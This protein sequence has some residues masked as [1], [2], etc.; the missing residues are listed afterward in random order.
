[1][2][3]NTA[4]LLA[5]N[6]DSHIV[7]DAGAGTGKTSTIVDRVIEHYLCEDQRATRILPKP[8]RP[9]RLQSGLLVSGSAERIDLRKWGGLLPGEVVL[10]TFTNRA[11]DEMR[12]RLRKRISR[13]KPGSA[14]DDGTYRKDP[15]IRHQGFNE[16]LLTLLDDAPIGTIDSF[17]NQ[18]VAPYRGILGDA[19]SREN[20]SD[21]GRILLTESALNTL[22]RLPNSPNL[23]GEA[24]DAGI[25]AE[26]AESVLAARDRI[27]RHYSGRRRATSVLRSLVNRSVFIEE[28]I[29]NLLDEKDAISEELLL[30][31]ILESI[32][33]KSLNG[34]TEE[35]HRLIDEYC[36]SVKSHIADLGGAWDANTRIACLDR[37][38]DDGPGDQVW[39]KLIWLGHILQCTANRSTW[40]N[41][42]ITFFPR[43]SLPN[44]DWPKGIENFGSLKSIFDVIVKSFNELWSTT[45]GQTYLHFTRT[46]ILL[47]ETPP[48]CSNEN[49]QSPLATLPEELPEVAPTVGKGTAH[50]FSLS[51]EARNLDDLRLILRGF[52]GILAKLKARDEVHDFDD[53]Q[54]LAGDLLLANCPEACREFYHP[55]IQSALDKPSDE[56]WRD[57]NIFTAFAA[58][59]ALEA[60]PSRAGEAAA[61]LGQIRTD[62]THRY[63]L[64]K[65]IR[66]RYRAFII[67]EAQDNSPLQ[68]RLLARLWGEREWVDGDPEIPNTP[69]QPTVCYVGDVKQSIYAFRQAEVTGFRTYA[70]TLRE[71]NKQ[72]FASLSELTRNPS[73]RSETHSRD[74]RNDHPLTIVQ[75]T[76]IWKDGG[77][78]LVGWIP[79]DATDQGLSSPSQEE[80][81]KRV[82]G[83]VSLN[84]NYRTDGGLLRVMN[85]WWTDIFSPRHRTV[86]SGDF[87]ADSQELFACPDLTKS[88]GSIEWLCPLNKEIT[89]DPPTDLYE[90]LD[91]FGPGAPN[92]MERQGMMIALRIKSLIEGRSIRVK[93]PDGRWDVLSK[94]KPVPA[95]EIMVLLPTRARIRDIIIRYLN[96][97]GIDAQADR[98]GG[99]LERPAVHALDGLLQLIA[100]PF[101]RHNAAW[102]ARSSLVGF[103]DARLQ[104]FI[105]SAKR[106]E[107][108][109]HRMAEFAINSRQKNLIDRWIA[110]A[111]TGRITELLEDTLDCSDLL[112]TYPDTT[113]LQDVEQ[114]TQLVRS[115][116][117]EVGGDAIV[118]ADRIRDLRERD[119]SAMEAVT[120]PPKDAVRVM[121]IHGSKGLQASVIFLVDI[122]SKR[123]TNLNHEYRSRAIVSPEI[124]AGSPLPWTDE[125]KTKSGVWEHTKWLYQAR[126]DAEARRLLYVGATR[127]KHR[128]ILVGSPKGTIWKD[129]SEDEIAG[130]PS[131]LQIPWNYSK[132]MPQLGQIWLE[133]LRQGS[134]RRGESD[135]IWNR[136]DDFESDISPSTHNTIRNLNPFSM[137]FDAF[138]GEKNLSGMVVLHHSDCFSTDDSDDEPLYTPLQK[139]ERTNNAAQNSSTREKVAFPPAR[140][141]SAPRIRIAPHRLS[142]LGQCSRRHWFETRGGLTSDPIIPSSESSVVTGMPAGVDAAT[143]GK[144]IHRIVELGIPNPGCESP[145]TPLGTSWTQSNDDK[146]AEQSL[147]N[148]VYGELFPAGGDKKTTQKLVD[149]MINNLQNGELGNLVKGISDDSGEIVEGLRTE[150]PFH[151]SMPAPLGGLIRSRWTPDG[152]KPLA[153]ID[154]AFIE[155]DGIIDLVL[156][157]IDENGPSIRP[158][159]FKTEEAWKL[160]S[161]SDDGLL[162]GSGKVGITPQCKAEIDMLLHHRMQLALYYRA[163]ESLEKFRIEAGFATRKVLRPAIWIG[164]TGRLV[165]Y[166]QDMFEQAQRDLDDIL[167]QAASMA[168]SSNEPLSNHQRLS[169]KDAE[170]CQTC[171]FNRGITP[172]CGPAEMQIVK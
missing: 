91:A 144:I 101:D 108:L 121:T 22:W 25:S 70:R 82:E 6:L 104:L 79:F 139:I 44:D 152:D 57:E 159:D 97:F 52:Q 65:K 87:Y 147:H 29:R 56:P 73:L 24:V 80:V 92:S 170:A 156:C 118:I 50:R 48:P 134:W 153:Q 46:A 16:Q 3:L 31:R 122:F 171:P 141:D 84:V 102:V 11:A 62:L 36:Q 19:L 90:Y 21:S 78:D 39:D 140:T 23:I 51:H 123:Q 112:A 71:V 162:E 53:I 4:Q 58:L 126:K 130:K 113:S 132:T 172:I 85:Q 109:L 10:L 99:L 75:A 142:I 33:E 135:S 131:G 154:K 160:N 167:I 155:M 14:S 129:D 119:S 143:L 124:F 55:S 27:Q 161:N 45:V 7:V 138:T 164:V 20:V 64:L 150:M 5:L 88:S 12:D 43:A 2:Q 166:P 1:M 81:D 103:D 120:I 125:D 49:W 30:G 63:G 13:L 83:H 77:R 67:D 68:W 106:D 149:L 41:K 117:I 116:M 8:E 146:M 26:I 86:P 133:S 110:L 136:E 148:Q 89:T 100:R 93:S 98:E 60:E 37:L 18:L 74:P 114:F 17:F 137:N 42:K 47:D 72:E 111:E 163:I 34:F 145:S 28:G 15:R 168:L 157:T 40:F 94:S 107:N 128:L 169:G 165:E 158:I 66:R 32:D 96:D 38:V 9:S 115:L 127:A 69:W 61:H 59:D 54:R 35:I 151:I 76:K 95:H 105:S